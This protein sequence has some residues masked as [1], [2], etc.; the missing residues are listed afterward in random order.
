MT[1]KTMKARTKEKYDYAEKIVDPELR[2]IALE[3]IKKE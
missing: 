3:W 1:R 2:K